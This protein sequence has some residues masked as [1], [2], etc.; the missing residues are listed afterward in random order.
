MSNNVLQK[1]HKLFTQKKFSAVL[2]MLEP[3]IIDFRD[4]AE[5]FYLLAVSC[6]Y[7]GD[8]GGT[9]SYLQRGRQIRLRDPKLLLAQAALFLRKGDTGQAVEFYLETLEYD[10][11]NKIA[12]KAMQFIRK[13]GDDQTLESWIQKEKIKQFYPPTGVYIPVFPFVILA[14]L[15][16]AGS[17]IALLPKTKPQTADRADLSKIVLS[18]D[19]KTKPVVADLS[20]ETYNLLLSADEVNKSYLQAQTFFQQYRDNSALV[21]INRILNSNAISQ[22]KQ[23]ATLLKD[24]LSPPTFETLQSDEKEN[25]S[26]QQVMK[27]PLFYAGCWVVWRG[28]VANIVTDETTFTCDFVIGYDT[29]NRIDGI[30]PLFFNQPVTIDTARSLQVLGNLAFVDGRLSLIGKT[31]YQPLSEKN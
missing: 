25:F 31:I 26:Y 17:V 19:E 22:I 27:N 21:E 24:F 9:Q 11:K 29:E 14:F 7:M 2:S 15:I 20:I 1:A 8:L 28:R 6:M 12:K 10:P 4:S 13:H 5:Y 18:T 3:K 23:K 30:I 16:V